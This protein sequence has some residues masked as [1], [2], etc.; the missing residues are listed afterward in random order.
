MTLGA[1]RSH[2]RRI[3]IPIG[4]EGKN[5]QIRQLH[6]SQIFYICLFETPEGH[7][8]GI[9]KNFTMTCEVT[10]G[11]TSTLIRETIE[12][13]GNVIPL[14]EIK[15]VTNIMNMVR[16][17]L[18]GN[19]VGVTEVPDEVCTELRDLRDLNQIP[20]EVSISFD[21][22]DKE[23]HIASDSGRL[24]RPLLSVEDNQLPE[25]DDSMTW[26]DMVD[27]G[28]IKYRDPAELENMVI[29]ME[30]SR[31]KSARS[32]IEFLEDMDD[33]E[34]EDSTSVVNTEEV[35]NYDLCEIHP[36]M[37]MGVCASIIPFPDHSQS[38]RNCYQ[39]AMGKQALG[40][41]ALSNNVRTDTVVHVLSGA[42]KPVTTTK[43]ASFMGFD[44][45][46]SGMNVNVA[47]LTYTG[48][49]QE[50]SI[51]MNKSA[52]DR[53]L[54]RVVTYKIASY[55]E[56]KKGTSYQESIEFPP[57]DVRKTFYQYDK[58]GDDGIIRVGEKVQKNDVLIGRVMTYTNKKGV[59][60]QKDCSRVAKANEKGVV[61]RVF[62]GTTPE[63]FK[64]IKIKIRS[65]RIPQVGD[66]FASRSAQKRNDWSKFMPMKTCHLR[67]MVLLL[68]SLSTLTVFHLV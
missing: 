26:Y 32:Q 7:S 11:V 27:M 47:I 24:I 23:I 52:I 50:D 65:I 51:I 68:I 33:L 54:F 56:K 36:S 19:I 62:L 44:N 28:I 49:N 14:V 10:N 20:H 15:D 35:V 5:T 22:Y 48:F 41:Y 8:S 67:K 21:K 29:A 60:E 9:V 18:N 59:S 25:I 46:P 13:V 66:K 63:G 55:I 37:M 45:L 38:P 43:M 1:F 3:V 53:G 16:I 2:L 30:Q 39:S 42:Q 64:F 58:L 6:G 40:Q 12:Q 17:F 4:K 34:E 31:L 57:A 61:D